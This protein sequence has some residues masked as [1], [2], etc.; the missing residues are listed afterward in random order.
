MLGDD[1]LEGL[2][3]DELE[4]LCHLTKSERYQRI[5]QA[6]QQALDRAAREQRSAAQHITSHHS[7]A[8]RM[9]AAIERRAPLAC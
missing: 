6:V 9:A 7:T 3:F 4:T 5:M 8:Q 1:L 2:K